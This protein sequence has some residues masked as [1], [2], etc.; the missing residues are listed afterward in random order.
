MVLGILLIAA[1]GLAVVVARQG[2]GP[3][4]VT[5]VRAS[6]AT[7]STTTSTTAVVDPSASTTTSTPGAAVP[8]VVTPP[9]TGSPGPTGPAITGPDPVVTTAAPPTLPSNETPQC[10]PTQADQTLT[11]DKAKYAPG[12]PVSVTATIRNH[13]ETSCAIAN[14][15]TNCYP[16]FSAIASNGAEFWRSGPAPTGPCSPP[17]R[18]TLF[19]GA[20]AS[21][22][23]SWDQ[24][25]RNGGPRVPGLYTIQSRW[26]ASSKTAT[27][28]LLP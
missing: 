2:R 11:P 12:E 3:D 1:V 16:L 23:A 22:T 8:T 4:T 13:S 20:A 19:P 26:L 28:E 15:N 14:P 5:V 7:S 25:D 6:P 27:L 10:S 24:S 17:P 9:G 18:Q 21:Y